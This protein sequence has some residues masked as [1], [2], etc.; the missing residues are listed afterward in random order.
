MIDNDLGIKRRRLLELKIFCNRTLWHSFRQ[1]NVI[2][3][4]DLP[5]DVLKKLAKNP[6]FSKLD[7][8]SIKIDDKIYLATMPAYRDDSQI[9]YVPQIDYTLDNEAATGGQLYSSLMEDGVFE[10][11]DRVLALVKEGV[12]GKVG[13]LAYLDN[14]RP[15]RIDSGVVTGQ[16]QRLIR[17]KARKP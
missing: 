16:V 11:F 9:W 14:G 3:K 5:L 8:P 1:K 10:Q 2:N 4:K 7:F 12:E 15:R 17:A 13:T 6:E